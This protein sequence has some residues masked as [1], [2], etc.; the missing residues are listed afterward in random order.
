MS[1]R[2]DI[3][4][5]NVGP[6]PGVKVLDLSRVLEGPWATQILAYFGACVWKI[7]R[8]GVGANHGKYSIDLDIAS[9]EHRPILQKVIERADVLVEH[10]KVGTL[11]KCQLDYDSVQQIKPDIIYA[12]ITGFGPTGPDAE[13]QVNQGRGGLMSITGEPEKAQKT[14]V[15]VA[16][17]MTGIYT[18]T[19]TQAL[20]HRD[21]MKTMT[22]QQQRQGQH[23]DVALLDTQ[24]AWAANQNMNYLVGGT[25]LSRC[26]T[27]H[28]HIVSYQSFA[29]IAIDGEFMLAVGNDKQFK[30]CV[31]ARDD[32]SWHTA[33]DSVPTHNVHATEKPR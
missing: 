26:G 22:G 23:V 2:R 12:S 29:A 16:D 9:S 8:P 27:V 17:L 20:Y 25:S 24:V 5:L 7:E 1:G 10:F 33:R 28:P 11:A 21:T 15:A 6:L 18:V 32:Q 3:Q 19:G 14:G 31:K 30:Q 4:Y 13:N